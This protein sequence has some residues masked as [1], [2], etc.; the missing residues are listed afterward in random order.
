MKPILWHNLKL[1]PQ[2]D[3]DD[4]IDDAALAVQGDGTIAWLGPRAAL[5][6]GYAHWP[7]E[8]LGG[9]WVTPGLVDC[10]THLIYGGQRADEFA[11][12]LAGA[13]Y[14]EVARRGGGI[15][16]TV[17]ATREADEAQLFAQ[18]AARL[19]PLLSEGVTAI[20]IK[21]GYGLDLASERKMLRVARQLGERFPVAVY[22]TFLG[23]HALPPEYAGRADAYIDEVCE[24]MLPALADE[25]LVDAV[26]VFCE[27]I[28]FSL[29]QS[30]RVFEAA[31]RRGLPVKMH[32][33][34]LSNGGGTALAARYRA[35]SA[36]HLEFLDEAGV[37]AMKA[38]GTVAVLLPGAYYF[39][40]ETQLPPLDLL[41]KHR[42]PIALATDHNPG[43][44]PLT[45][46]L[47]TL[48][49][50]CT[51]FRMTVPEVLLGVTRHAAAALGQG[52][53]HGQLAAGRQAD[54][55]VWPVASL[56]ELA[57]WFGRPLCERV[58]K[59]G[60]TVYQRSAA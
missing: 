14:E 45:S 43:T 10:H 20:E 32:A 39:I 7:H 5:P 55:A 8:D 57:Y 41:R 49:L 4:T 13:S 24:R 36:D 23:A 50:A 29:A 11:L 25:G 26:D 9:A 30:E 38:A 44:S 27:R 17:R 51:L 1:C 3:P 6:D 59:G 52:A 37:E 47:L 40:R 56:A 60:V 58:V 15:V 18:A 21:S 48:N 19:Q 28:G 35:L 2:G 46:L 22:T 12:R 42:V 54:F 31:A 34:Q 33:E 53:R 16:S